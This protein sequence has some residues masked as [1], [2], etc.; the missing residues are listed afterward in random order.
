MRKEAVAHKELPDINDVEPMSSAD[1]ACLSAIHAVLKEHD[2]TNKFGVIL[3]HKHF[4][5]Y[6]D[7]VLLETCDN[8]TRTL[9]IKPVPMKDFQPQNLISTTWRF[10]T[11]PSEASAP[12]SVPEPT[13]YCVMHCYTLTVCSVMPGRGHYSQPIHNS[14]H[15]G[16]QV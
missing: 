7:E 4:E 3:L 12:L 16:Q 5:V 14:A 8:E 15:T 13:M 1:D 2:A 9:T 10:D 6:E 11:W